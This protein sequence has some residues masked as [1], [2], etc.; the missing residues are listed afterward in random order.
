[1]SDFVE[2]K[3][4]EKDGRTGEKSALHL[5]A[6]HDSVEIAKVLIEKGCRIDRADLK[7]M[8]ASKHGEV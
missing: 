4:G 6:V 7:V 1:M 8:K 3:S 5:A 2:E